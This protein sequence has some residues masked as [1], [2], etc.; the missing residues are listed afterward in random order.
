VPELEALP[1]TEEFDLIVVSA[2]L[3]E[4]E[5]GRTLSAAGE[6]PPYVLS[7][8]T[9]AAELL[10]QVERTCQRYS[11]SHENGPSSGGVSRRKQK[12]P[13]LRCTRSWRRGGTDQ[14]LFS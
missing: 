6:T 12:R 2:S 11:T 4:L 8:L 10:A 7:G 14:D 13:R 3:S 9:L 5:R 1:R